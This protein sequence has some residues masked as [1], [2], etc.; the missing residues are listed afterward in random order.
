MTTANDHL[1]TSHQPGCLGNVRGGGG[2][3]P[4][5]ERRYQDSPYFPGLDV[6]FWGIA[7]MEAGLYSRSCRE[8]EGEHDE[9]SQMGG[10][11][12]DGG[13]GPDGR[14]FGAG[15]SDPR[16]PRRCDLS[17]VARPERGVLPQSRGDGL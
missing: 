10:S 14:C 15:V 7:S 4:R 13:T 2:W 12:V 3:P 9:G 16:Y 8:R 11:A 5:L 17:A 1:S 6:L